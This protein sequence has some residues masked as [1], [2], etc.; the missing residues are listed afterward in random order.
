MQHRLNCGETNKQYCKS[1][2]TLIAA[3]FLLN[4]KLHQFYIDWVSWCRVVRKS[5]SNHS[6]KGSSRERERERAKGKKI[7]LNSCSSQFAGARVKSINIHTVWMA[8]HRMA[9]ES[10]TNQNKTSEETL[11]QLPIMQ[12]A[13]STTILN[14][15]SQSNRFFFAVRQFVFF[16]LPS[17]L[18]LLSSVPHAPKS[19]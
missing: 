9:F 19:H 2:Y 12:L 5:E 7:E 8:C 13:K 1:I 14:Y 11:I 4:W 16:A 17:P 6:H 3:D 10:D 15:K 18:L